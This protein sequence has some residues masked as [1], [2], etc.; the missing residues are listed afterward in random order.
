M[1]GHIGTNTP[2]F[3]PPRWGRPPFDP[4][5]TGLCKFGWVWSSLRHASAKCTMVHH[6]CSD[7]VA[8]AIFCFSDDPDGTIASTFST[9]KS[10][11]G[12]Q[13]GKTLCHGLLRWKNACDCDLRCAAEFRENRSF[14]KNGGVCPTTSTWSPPETAL[15]LCMC[16]CMLDAMRSSEYA[17]LGVCMD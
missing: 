17:C 3:V 5:Q 14:C 15:S 7:G 1:S 13:N 16:V 4:T 11:Q 9:Q 2:K 8:V 10:K 12:A 6:G